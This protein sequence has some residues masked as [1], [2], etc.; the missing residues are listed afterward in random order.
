MVNSHIH[1]GLHCYSREY[2]Y[3]YIYGGLFVTGYCQFIH[4]YVKSHRIDKILFLARDGDVLSKAYE[5]LYPEEE[6]KWEY[7]SRV[8][9]GSHKIGSVH[10]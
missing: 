3:G 6:G 2:E 5:I 10:I 1:N 8:S 4:E 9:I 7:V